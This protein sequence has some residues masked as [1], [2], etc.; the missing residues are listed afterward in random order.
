MATAALTVCVESV[1]SDASVPPLMLKA[2]LN[3]T[4]CITVVAEFAIKQGAVAP[5]TVVVPGVIVVADPPLAVMTPPDAV[6]VVPSTLTNPKVDADPKATAG[7]ASD[8]MNV[9]AV[10]LLAV[11]PAVAVG[12]A[13]AAVLTAVPPTCKPVQFQ[14]VVPVATVQTLVPLLLN[15]LMSFVEPCPINASPPVVLSR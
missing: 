2:E 10:P 4:H 1:T 12:F 3:A 11:D 5:L 6:I 9:V 14:F 7:D 13:A 8:R 15:T